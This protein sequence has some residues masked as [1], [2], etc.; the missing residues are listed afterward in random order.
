MQV[1]LP[2]G[3]DKTVS[4]NVP[5]ENFDG[6]LK[7]GVLAPASDPVRAI[8]RAVDRPIGSPTLDKIVRSGTRVAVICDDLSRPT[9]VSTVLPVILDRLIRAGVRRED[10]HMVMALGSHR[11]MTPDEIRTRVG[12][13][14]YANYRVVNSEFRDPAS[15]I[16]LGRTADGVDI[17]VTREA[18]DADVRIGIGNIVPHPVMG[19]SG[20]GKILF[21]GVTGEHTVAQFHMLGG[22]SDQRLVGL[23]D[24]HVRLRMESWVPK[25]GLDFVVNTILDAKFRIVR[26][27]A[28]DYIK[29]HRA[30]VETAKVL[31][32]CR[33]ERPADVIVVSSYPADEDFWQSAKGFFNSEGGLKDAASTMILVTPNY[34]GMGPHPEYGECTGDDNVGVRLKKLYDGEDIPGDPLAIAVGTSMSKLRRRC[35]LVVVSDGVTRAEMDECKIE[36]YPLCELQKAVDVTLSRYEHPVVAAVSH[37]GE[38]LL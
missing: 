13:D 19:W 29:A 6:F 1:T 11:A 35:R 14:V 3:G 8:E 28:G 32:R 7:P 33:M 21:P 18:M 27:V 2:Y 26:V 31:M 38:Y 5:E 10:I 17:V 20:G 25:I 24:S 4:F 16:N 22:L 12:A 36:H 37:G 9:P 23:E 15:L 30:G 34:E